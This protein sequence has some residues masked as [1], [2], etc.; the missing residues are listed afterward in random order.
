MEMYRNRCRFGGISGGTLAALLLAWGAAVA[1]PYSAASNDPAN[2]FDPPIAATSPQFTGWASAVV[3]YSPSPQSNSF[4][5][6]ANALGPAGPAT[7]VVSLGD[8]TAADL[9]TGVPPGSLTVGFDAPIYNGPGDDFA[10]FEN[11]FLFGGGIFGELA[12]VEVS[13]DGANFVRFP[14]VS[15]T[16]SPVGAFGTFDPTDVYNLAGKHQ[17]Q[18]GT[19]FDLDDVTTDSLVLAGAVDL[20]QIRYVRL[21]D[22]PGRGDFTDSLGNPIYD[23]W[24]TVGS[25]GLDLDAVGVVNTVL[26]EIAVAGTP[27]VPFA[28]WPVDA[29]PSPAQ[30]VVL[31]NTGAGPLRFTTETL[32]LVGNAAF[33]V[34]PTAGM[35]DRIDAGTSI[36]LRIASNPGATGP[37]SATLQIL[38]NALNEP[39]VEIPL[40]GAGV[41][42][43][44]TPWEQFAGGPKGGGRQYVP[45]P[46]QRLDGPTWQTTDESLVTA[47]SV[48]VLPGTPDRVIAWG[49]DR[50]GTPFD[51]SD[52]TVFLKAFHADTGALMWSSPGLEAG[53]TLSFDSW[54]T[55]A[56]DAASNSVYMATGGTLYRLDGADGSIVWSTPLN[57]GGPSDIVNGS[58]TV[59]GG[60]AYVNTYG[61]FAPTAKR[62]YA[63]N[64]ADG[65][66]DW[67]VQEGGQGSE[68]PVYVN[69][70]HGEI[71]YTLIAQGMI[72]RNAADGSPVWS[73]ADPLEGSAWSTTNAFF[74][75]LTYYDGMLLAPTY[76]FGGLGELVAVDAWTG[77]LLWRQASAPSGNSSPV[78][79]AGNVWV[80]GT[81]GW[82]DASVLA[83]FAL[84]DGSPVRSRELS[85]DSTA[86]NISP[87]AYNDALAVTLG[88][89]DFFPGAATGLR[90][91]NPAD[92]GYLTSPTT[93]AQAARGTPAI[94][95]D[96]R[97]YVL[98]AP[99]GLAAYVPITFNGVIAADVDGTV[100]P[101]QTDDR[102]VEITI[103]AP[104]ASE[105][106][107]AEANGTKD[108]TTAPWVPFASET[109]F[110]VSAGSGLKTIEIQVRNGSTQSAVQQVTIEYLAPT[111][112]PDWTILDE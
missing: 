16:P 50:A 59:G 49:G 11:G 32:R 55:P 60:R 71:V 9:D 57:I 12:F 42:P 110:E 36:T 87:V 77:R 90:L 22:I 23:P 95:A 86:W 81:E 93:D 54:H 64:I 13:S 91:I 6:S 103:D 25:G 15:L 10:V 20:D 70:G 38:S 31:T 1:G 99:D 102:L 76:N 62:L 37:T 78:V 109:T 33:D 98:R 30:S 44:P 79:L 51:G 41:A 100:G 24:L 82:G 2:P 18:W 105:M 104:F 112:V 92:G 73:S 85:P 89:D 29:G 66:I 111:S 69:N 101:G 8:L 35:L 74:G 65:T 107:L 61:G 4:T 17:S 84:E 94:G 46:L 14:S 7:G 43:Q 63:V 21:V 40:N 48:V 27:L 106:R 75:G 53:N 34:F 96:G 72:A 97:L 5:N 3:N 26:P 108:I 58:V 19:P 68:A 28:D 67:S 56:A 83:A 45:N 88:S 47:G 39:V 52:D 80:S